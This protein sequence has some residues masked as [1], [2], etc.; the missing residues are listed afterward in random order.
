MSFPGVFKLWDLYVGASLRVY[1]LRSHI[2]LLYIFCAGKSRR[3]RLVNWVEK[4]SFKKIQKL[5][6]IFERERHNEILLTARNLHELTRSPSPY[7]IPVIPLPLPTEIVEGEHYVIVDLLNLALG[8]S[9]PAKTFET[10]TVGRELV[11]STQPEQPSLAREDS[12]LVPQAYEEDDRSSRFEHLSFAKKGSRP[13][14]QAS[15]K[16][17]RVPERPKT[18]GAGVEDFVP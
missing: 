14:P 18:P 9:S 17:R 15:K 6:E 13:T 16:G 10:E 5:L 1:P 8:S 4:A 3:S 11:I 12:S 7:I 2:L